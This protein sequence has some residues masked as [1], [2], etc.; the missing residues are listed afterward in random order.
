MKE[1]LDMIEF[2]PEKIVCGEGRGQSIRL[3]RSFDNNSIGLSYTTEQHYNNAWREYA[4]NMPR[5]ISKSIRTFEVL[6][7]LQAEMGKTMNGCL[8]FA[9]HEHQIIKYV[10]DWFEKEL[11]LS[12]VKWKWSIKLNINEPEDKG[13]KEEVENKV[14]K[15]WLEKTEISLES[16]YP[17]KVTYIKNTKNKKISFYDYGTLVLEYK[18]N[19]FSQIIKN[20]VRKITYEKIL[21]YDEDLIRAYMKGVIAGEGCIESDK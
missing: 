11:E 13:Y 10:M 7:L 18:N 4:A 1:K 14:I 2:L 6:G 12:K 3:N 5:C 8:S 17:K 15:H 19:L 16:A 21:N 9:N 20:F